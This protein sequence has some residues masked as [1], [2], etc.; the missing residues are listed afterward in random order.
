MRYPWLAALAAAVLALGV[1][2]C[3]ERRQ[4]QQRRQRRRRPLRARHDRRLEHRLPVRPGRGR[5]L[6]GR[7]PGRQGHGR[8]VRHRRRLRE[9]L[10]R[11]D[12]HLRRLASD[13]RRRGGSRSARRTAIKYSEVQVANDGIAV[14]TNTDLKIDCLTTDQLKTLWKQG[15]EDLELQPARNSRR[16]PFPDAKVSLY[17]PG[18]DSGTF[19][20]FTE[21]INGEK[22]ATRKDYQPSEDDNVLVQGVEG[23]K[24]GLGYFGFSYYEDNA[25]KLNLVAV[26]AGDG[27]VKPRQDDDPGQHL[28]AA[29]ASAVHVPAT[30]PSLTASRRSRA[31]WT[32]RSTTPRSSPTTAQIVPLTDEQLTKAKAAL[33]DGRGPVGRRARG[34]RFHI[35]AG[36]RRRVP[37]QVLGV[38]QRHYG[39]KVIKALLF[40][41]ALVSILITRRDRVLAR[42]GETIAFFQDDVV[43]IKE[44]L[45]GT[46]WSPL[47]ADPAASA[48]RPLVQ[49]TLIISRHRAARRGPARPRHRDLPERVRPA[50]RAQDRQAD[51]RAARRRPDDRL[52]L[53]R[54]DLLHAEDPQ[55]PAAP[56]RHR[57]QRARR[58]H[59][60][61]HHDHPDDR[62][63]RR[64]RDVVGAAELRE[65]AYGLGAS[66]R[67]VVDCASC[68]RPRSRASSRRVVLG[69]SRAVGETMIVLIAAG[70]VADDLAR[71][72][73]GR[74]RR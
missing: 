47:F 52:R 27:C 9:V 19:D 11:R 31:S 42:C 5:G 59:H 12:R 6:P 15:F 68:S 60:H 32:T 25:D 14:V 29:L 2:A 46:K 53:L 34:S 40:L 69:A 16:T 55:R 26:D 70:Q 41:A 20:F 72:A 22:G 3:G 50:A 8:Q 24:S 45:T 66:K 74:W 71:S 4:R 64:G 67:Q 63:D 51:P 54:A 62:V 36:A 21:E 65:G 48:I 43:T 7:E 61:R 44:F 28:Q 57:L 10:R 58:R 56:R 30:R 23:D 13:R 73:R 37:R 39:E 1:A 18:T 38:A 49:G 17:G 35:R 33:T